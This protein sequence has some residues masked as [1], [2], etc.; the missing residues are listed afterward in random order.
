MIKGVLNVEIEVT[1]RDGYLLILRPSWAG[2]DAVQQLE[3]L[4]RQL[5]ERGYR[6]RM[7]G[8]AET[9]RLRAS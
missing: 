2:P 9:R 7:A 3:A 8:P 5:R 6:P 4:L 1:T